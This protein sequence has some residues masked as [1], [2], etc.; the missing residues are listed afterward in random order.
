MFD[1]LSSR[2]MHPLCIEDQITIITSLEVPQIIF[3]QCLFFY[4]YIFFVSILPIPIQ[5]KTFIAKVSW[6]CS[7][8][9]DEWQF[10]LGLF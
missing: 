5:Y 6:N 9:S 10:L 7:Q 4:F 2:R 3:V 8:I 1:K